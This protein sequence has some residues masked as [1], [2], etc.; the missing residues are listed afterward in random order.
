MNFE[1]EVGLRLNFIGARVQSA[2]NVKMLLE[3][4][5]GEGEQITVPKDSFG[6]IMQ[7]RKTT[8]PWSN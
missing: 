6:A 5:T 8:S 4:V 3:N 1:F 2:L 7:E